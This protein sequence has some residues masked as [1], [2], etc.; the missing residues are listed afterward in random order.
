MLFCTLKA[1][2]LSVADAVRLRKALINGRY[3]R[4]AVDGSMFGIH[5]SSQAPTAHVHAL[6]FLA[7]DA[8]PDE[9]RAQLGRV[10]NLNAQALGISHARLSYCQ[11]V[12]ICE[13]DQESDTIERILRYLL[14]VARPERIPAESLLLSFAAVK[15]Q[16]LTSS[17]GIVASCWGLKAEA[18]PTTGPRFRYGFDHQRRALL[19]L[20]RIVETEQTREAG[21]IEAEAQ[22]GRASRA[23]RRKA[24]ARQQ[25]KAVEFETIGSRER[26]AREVEAEAR[27][28]EVARKRRRELAHEWAQSTRNQPPAR[29]ILDCKDRVQALKTTPPSPRKEG[30][31]HAQGAKDP[32]L[33]RQH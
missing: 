9:F 7:Q 18:E 33:Q 23:R 30:T 8:D 15:G 13:G 27:A 22:A 26:K 32:D 6:V 25:Q 19:L 2:G 17:S 16:K 12:R 28:T 1:S 31:N 29:S 24:E 20:G 4:A 10:W 5:L 21:Q 3:F 11:P 14:S